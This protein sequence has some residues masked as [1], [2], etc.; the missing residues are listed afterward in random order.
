MRGIVT[1]FALIDASKKNYVKTIRNAITNVD[2]NTKTKLSTGT[3]K[4]R[5]LRYSGKFVKTTQVLRESVSIL[6]VF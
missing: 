5:G 3:K 4:F 1:P 6:L 2:I